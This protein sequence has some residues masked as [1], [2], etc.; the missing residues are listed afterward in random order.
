MQRL[1]IT[2][3]SGFVGSAMCRYLARDGRRI[4]WEAVDL[5]PAFDLR[6][7]AAMVRLVE[8]VRP[9]AVLH[10]AAQSAVPES[11]RDPVSTIEV[12]VLGTLNL[13]Q[14]LKAIDFTGRLVH[15]GT[16][17]VYGLVPEAD[18]PVGE[19]RL[20]RPRNPYAVSKLA[21]EAL[22]WQWYASD[23]MDVVL[24]RAFNH[25]GWG[26]SDR[27]AIASFARQL[28]EIRRGARAPV[29][30][31]GDLGVTRDFTDV[32]DVAAAYIALLARGAAGEVYNVCSGVERRVGDLL[33]QMIEIAQVDVTVREDAHRLRPSEQRRMRGDPGKILAATGWQAI[34]PIETSLQSALDYWE[35]QAPR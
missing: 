28:V 10:L 30:T 1:I 21:S 34:T 33:Q 7:R 20:P 13:L 32:D 31:T 23:G 4:G 24:A 18:L 17:E 22:C 3:R 25:I 27:F 5:P 26:Q 19:A 29:I 2:G 6:N 11:F 9:D 12:N 16:G 14:A 8:D 15:A 35:G